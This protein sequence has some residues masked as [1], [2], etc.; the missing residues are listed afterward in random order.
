[1]SF[2]K[3]GELVGPWSQ[4]ERLLSAQPSRWLSGRLFLLLPAVIF[5][6]TRTV[7]VYVGL[8][9]GGPCPMLSLSVPG[10]LF[11]IEAQLRG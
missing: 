2:V 3:D 11:L 4:A 7:G 10:H 1:M 8:A 5:K 6:R 9:V